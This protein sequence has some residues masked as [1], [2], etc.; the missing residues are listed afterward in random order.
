MRFDQHWVFDLKK[1]ARI[2]QFLRQ[3]KY[4]SIRMD[5]GAE[6]YAS[7]RVK[8]ILSIEL[9]VHA[10]RWAKGFRLHKLCLH[11][12][13]YNSSIAAYNQQQHKIVNPSALLRRKEI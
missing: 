8:F 5:G 3:N 13:K 1:M 11:D 4:N 6:K 12:A 2:S 9:S 7:W 10:I